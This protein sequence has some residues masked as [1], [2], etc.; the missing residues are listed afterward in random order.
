[1]S[2][3]LTARG[4]GFAEVVADVPGGRREAREPAPSLLTRMR[5]RTGQRAAARA[6]R[7]AA[8]AGAPAQGRPGPAGGP[9]GVPGTAAGASPSL[10]WDR[11]FELSFEVTQSAFL[12]LKGLIWQELAEF[13]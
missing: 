10:A 4:A 12:F 9:R 2:R 7:G 1:M 13:G 6:G 8:R 11:G 5:R 3:V